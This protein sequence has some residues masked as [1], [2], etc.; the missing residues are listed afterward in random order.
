[1]VAALKGD[2]KTVKVLLGAGADVDASD[3]DGY[4]ALIFAAKAGH[5]MVV[6]QLLDGGAD[7]DAKAPLTFR[8]RVFPGIFH[9]AKTAEQHARI[10]DHWKVVHTLR[11]GLKR[12]KHTSSNNFKKQHEAKRRYAEL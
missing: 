2:A 11:R 7:V 8:E 10:E 9:V 5:V 12:E 1:M 6:E 4:T 3:R